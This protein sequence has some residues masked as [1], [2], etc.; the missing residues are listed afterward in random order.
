VLSQGIWLAL[1][2]SSYTRIHSIN[3]SLFIGSLHPQ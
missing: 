1:Y 3:S 2:I